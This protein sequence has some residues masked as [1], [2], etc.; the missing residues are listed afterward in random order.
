MEIHIHSLSYKHCCLFFPN[1]WSRAAALKNISENIHTLVIHPHM[2]VNTYVSIYLQRISTSHDVLSVWIVFQSH[3][4]EADFKEPHNFKLR[5]SIP[6][7]GHM[8]AV[9]CCFPQTFW[10]LSAQNL[11]WCVF[12]D[13]CQGSINS[14]SSRENS[15]CVFLQLHSMWFVL[16]YI[17]HLSPNLRAPGAREHGIS[18]LLWK[19][20]TITLHNSWLFFLSIWLN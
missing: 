5:G 4:R 6:V 8:P 13:G 11:A 18:E 2:K 12:H 19:A 7:T 1:S 3:E 9:L 14:S 10:N 16:I 20:R 15:I 17:I